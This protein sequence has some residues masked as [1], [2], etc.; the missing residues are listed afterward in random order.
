MEMRRWVRPLAAGFLVAVA[1]ASLV[2]CGGG[3]ATNVGSGSPRSVPGERAPGASTGSFAKGPDATKVSDVPAPVPAAEGSRVIRSGQVAVEVRTGDFD[4]AFARVISLAGEE[5]GVVSGSDASADG[6]RIRSG[7]LTLSVPAAHFQA[8]LDRL[9]DLGTVRSTHVTSQDVSQQYV[10]LQARLANAESERDA[11]L[12]LMQKAQTV[13]EILSVQTQLGQY[14]QQVE[15]LKGQIDYL[16]HAT[17][18]W[19]VQVSIREAGVAAPKPPV[20][21]W[22]LATAFWTGLHAFVQ[23]LDGL[24]VILTVAGP[25]LL[26]AL[27]GWLAWRRRHR[28]LGRPQ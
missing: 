13:Q 18:M 24:I 2:A 19:T 14:T 11:M 25:Y 9:H 5:G 23:T 8:T 28:L 12:A 6:D 10:D 21:E 15:Q 27:L 7:T 20:D 3:S 4:A 16:D 22:G 17:A 1:G 26:A